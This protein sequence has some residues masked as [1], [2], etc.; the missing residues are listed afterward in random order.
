LRDIAFRGWRD[1]SLEKV[2][3][4]LLLLG[5]KNAINWIR[6][7]QISLPSLSLC[8]FSFDNIVF[9][10]RSAENMVV[11]KCTELALVGESESTSDLIGCRSR[12]EMQDIIIV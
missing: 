8:Y 7:S 10:L 2:L 1:L 5:Q 9:D 4:C 12:I 3:S 11:I 6:A